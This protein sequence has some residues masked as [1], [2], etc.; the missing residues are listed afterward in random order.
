[1]TG[2]HDALTS[3]RNLYRPQRIAG[4]LTAFRIRQGLKFIPEADGFTFEADLS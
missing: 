4:L 3:F 2:M 1:M